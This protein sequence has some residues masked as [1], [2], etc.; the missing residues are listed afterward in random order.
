MIDL[1]KLQ[2]AN[3][4]SY[5]RNKSTAIAVFV[6]V[7]ACLFVFFF[8]S[9]YIFVRSADD[10][11]YTEIGKEIDIG[12]GHT[13][14]VES[15]QYSENENEMEVVLSFNN[16]SFDGI[17]T[18]SYSAVSRNNGNNTQNLKTEALYES[19]FFSVVK[20]SQLKSFTEVRLT[21]SYDTSPLLSGNDKENQTNYAALF[22]NIKKVEKT[23]GFTQKDIITLYKDKLQNQINEINLEI[24][25]A[26]SQIS[27][28]RKIQEN[29]LEKVAEI[30]DNQQYMTETELAG[31]ESQIQSYEKSY[32]DYNTQ[33]EGLEA[34]ISDYSEEIEERQD[35]QKELDNLRK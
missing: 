10:M 6:A 17:D 22:T 1:K 21:V 24:A 25:E 16:T 11:L 7:I 29:I 30:R 20:I 12:S 19:S 18:Y 3:G 23:D 5:L 35:K 26:N 34:Q 27:E 8:A 2:K 13:V 32:N 4:K 31:S 15:W 33:I 28:Y 14:T 9:P